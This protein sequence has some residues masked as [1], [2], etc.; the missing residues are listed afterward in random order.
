M[1][2]LHF[3]AHNGVNHGTAT[4]AAAHSAADW[5]LYTLLITLLVVGFMTACLYLLR[6]FDIITIPIK[7]KE[8]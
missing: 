3:F 4:E 1:Q 5:I 7:D 6:R 2:A 8:K